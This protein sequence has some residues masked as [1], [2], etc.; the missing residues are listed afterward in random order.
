MPFPKIKWFATLA[1][2]FSVQAGAQSPLHWSGKKTKWDR[3]NNIVELF[4]KAQVSRQGEIIT[5]DY[6]KLNLETNDLSA[7]GQCVY[8]M[9]DMVVRAEELHF[10]LSTRLGKIVRGKITNGQFSL[11]GSEIDRMGDNQFI[12]QKGEY[13]TCHDCASS[14]SV[15]SNE[16]K[17]TIGGYAHMSNVY[18]KIKD[19]PIFW[20]PYLILPIKNKR[21]SGILMPKTVIAGRNGTQVVLPFFWNINPW[22]D[23]TIGVGTYTARGLRLE[24]EGR[25]ALSSVSF[26]NMNFWYNS[27]KYDPSTGDPP[28][29]NGLA[30][31]RWS[32]S[33]NQTQEFPLGITEKLFI[34]EVSDTY[35]PDY[36]LGDVPRN[37]NPYLSSELSFSKATQNFSGFIEF[38]RTRNMLLESNL[39][40]RTFDDRTVQLAPRLLLTTNDQRIAKSSF[41]TGLTVGFS[42]FSRPIGYFDKDPDNLVTDPTIFIPGVDP[43]RKAIRM[44][45]IPSLYTTIKPFSGISLVPSA[46][47]RYYVYNFGN[48][49]DN[50]GRGYG[51]IKVDLSF[52][53]EKIFDTRNPASPRMKH[54]FRPYLTYN[55]IPTRQQPEDHPFISQ[56]EKVRTAADGTLVG[57]VSSYVFDN[58]DIVPY[59][60]TRNFQSFQ[61]PLGHSLT[62]GFVTQLIRRNSNLDVLN[63]SYQ[64][65]IEWSALQNLNFLE[66]SKPADTRIPLSRLQSNL[67][68]GLGPWGWTTEYQ[69]IPDIEKYQKPWK[70]AFTVNSSFSYTLASKRTGVLAFSRAISLGASYNPGFSNSKDVAATTG[71]TYSINDYI[72]PSVSLAYNLTGQV[73]ISQDFN[74]TLQDTSQ[75]WQLST[76]YFQNNQNAWGFRFD[77]K[78]NISGTGFGN[79]TDA[80]SYVTPPNT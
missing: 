76:G 1:L 57:P 55:L 16:I 70:D 78:L 69:W 62:Y 50:L 59:G 27:W 41:V 32:A 44:N 67:F 52:Q 4:E 80:A 72:M 48:S 17:M 58:Y 5:A 2:I 21:E 36:F 65:I 74:L 68:M 19:A 20:F 49:V 12:A 56:V 13:T 37:G 3:K 31:A 79:I 60:V 63:S 47:Y 43:L 10:N 38:K 7:I 24:W 73:W 40:L 25:Y 75:C 45:F 34:R 9:P 51:L 23:M 28:I 18:F 30:S 29:L 35:A 26:A 71:I 6:I 22:A 66:L 14:W 64:K 8:V 77:L 61:I 53:L 42:Q 15:L 39:D 11:Q 54:L 33:M 46:Q